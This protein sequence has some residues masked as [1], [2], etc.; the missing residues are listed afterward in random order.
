MEVVSSV[1]NSTDGVEELEI[2]PNPVYD[3]LNINLS[4]EIRVLD[5]FR[6]ILIQHRGSFQSEVDVQA[7]TPG[8]YLLEVTMGQRKTYR[9]FVKL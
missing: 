6:N 4:G 9:R 1:N 5:P 3:N 2:Y 8:I 7:L